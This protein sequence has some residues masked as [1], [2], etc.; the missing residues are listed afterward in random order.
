MLEGSRLTNL[1]H[2]VDL[3]QKKVLMQTTSTSAL[4]QG[5]VAE[6]KLLVRAAQKFNLRIM[7]EALGGFV[8]ESIRQIGVRA[9]FPRIRDDSYSAFDGPCTLFLFD[10]YGTTEMN[11]PRWIVGPTE[12]EALE[13]HLVLSVVEGKVHAIPF[14]KAPSASPDTPEPHRRLLTS[15]AARAPEL[16]PPGRE[17]LIGLLLQG[18]P[19]D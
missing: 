10:S 12:L 19:L 3:V 7:K 14:F 17:T 4:L 16:L 8:T 18:V 9:L 6:Q 5:K 15:I 2:N 13:L 11:G 1:S